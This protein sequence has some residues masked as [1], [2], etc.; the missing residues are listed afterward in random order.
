M[1][2]CSDN[3]IYTGYTPNLFERIKR[4][5]EGKGA[6]YTKSRLPVNLAYFEEFKD[7]SQA[8]KREYKLKKLKRKEKLL[9]I[10]NQNASN[11]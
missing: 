9:L 1:L 3:S 8:L 4:H 2:I 6:K 10:L 7:K 11:R 5:N